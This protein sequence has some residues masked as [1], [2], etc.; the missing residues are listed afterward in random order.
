MVRGMESAVMAGV[1]GVN[2]CRSLGMPTVFLIPLRPTVMWAPRTPTLRLG[3]D[4]EKLTLR[5]GRDEDAA[6]ENHQFRP[7]PVAIHLSISD[8]RTRQWPPSLELGITS[9]W[10]SL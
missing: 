10:A 3:P 7:P 2:R 6:V 1:R 5:P 8:F 9:S 4:F